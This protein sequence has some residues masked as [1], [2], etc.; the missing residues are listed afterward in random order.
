[1]VKSAIKT[2]ETSVDES[3]RENIL[4]PIFEIAF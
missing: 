3:Y 1:M 4:A 2:I